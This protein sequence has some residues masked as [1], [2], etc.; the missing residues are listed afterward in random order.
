M[1]GHWSL[2]SPFR[3]LPNSSLLPS[4]LNSQRMCVCVCVSDSWWS[5]SRPLLVPHRERAGRKLL[6][7]TFLLLPLCVHHAFVSSSS[8]PS[9][10]QLI[11]SSLFF[12]PRSPSQ[13]GFKKVFQ[14]HNCSGVQIMMTEAVKVKKRKRWGG[15]WYERVL[16]SCCKLKEMQHNRR[17]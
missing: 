6:N 4:S 12:C 3:D 10:C 17:C 5:R 2:A 15:N 16:L 7:V 11:L 9:S 13:I 8:P 1:C 14:K